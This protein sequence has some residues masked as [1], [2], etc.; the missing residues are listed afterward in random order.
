MDKEKLKKLDLEGLNKELAQACGT[1]NLELVKYLLISSELSIHPDIN[2]NN[3]SGLRWACIN[4]EV[5]VIKYLLA[6]PE[7][8]KHADVHVGDDY[9]F[10]HAI[11][12]ESKELLEFYIF[13]LSVPKSN[14]IKKYIHEDRCQMAK[15]MY[16]AKKLHDEL[17]K[18]LPS[19]K[20]Y[21]KKLKI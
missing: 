5:E 19:D 18:N 1:G 12:H 21:Q 6:S 9:P 10:K 2:A 7:L 8:K 13:E 14:F 20:I 4:N 16:K 15:E 11:K 3:D 17:D